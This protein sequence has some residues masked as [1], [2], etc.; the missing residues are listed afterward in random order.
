MLED[1]AVHAA[2]EDAVLEAVLRWVE[3]DEDERRGHLLGLL[4]HV[5]LR[6]ISTAC[7]M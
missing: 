3:H 6:R 4:D 7:L 2:T 5:R 1:E